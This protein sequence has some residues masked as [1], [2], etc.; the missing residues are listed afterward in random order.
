MRIFRV[1][2]ECDLILKGK[3]E[4]IANRFGALGSGIAA[5]GR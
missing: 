5:A 1:W 4:K 2:L 3:H